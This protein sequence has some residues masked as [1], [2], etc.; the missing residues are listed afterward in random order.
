MYYV[1]V[2][3][4]CVSYPSLVPRPL[5]PEERPGTHCLRM[6]E[7]FRYIFRKKLRCLYAE[8]YTNQEY[9]AFLE[10]DTSDDLTHRTQ[11]GYYFSDVAVSFLQT[12]SPTER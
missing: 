10:L 5:L 7:I 12:Y 11:L 3:C 4:I 8:D 6:L 9:R 2:S 1:L